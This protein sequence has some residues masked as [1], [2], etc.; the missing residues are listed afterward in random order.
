MNHYSNWLNSKI[1][2]VLLVIFVLLISFLLPVQGRGKER[3]PPDKPP[4]TPNHNPKIETRLERISTTASQAKPRAVRNTA[5]G[6]GIEL[7]RSNL[8]DVIV[9]EKTGSTISQTALRKVG[10]EVLGQTGNL[11]KV[12][13]P[14]DRIVDMAENLEGI[15]YVRSPYTSTTLGY[16]ST[17]SSSSYTSRGTNLI[18]GGLYH[19]NNYL[20]EGVK[21]AVIDL[22]FGSLDLAEEA[23]EIPGE[24]IED[25]EDYTGSGIY[26]GTAH[27]TGV[28]EIVHG[29]APEANLYL[30][31]IR[32]E[33]DLGEATADA[34][35]QGID[36]IV[37]SVGWLNTNFGDGT[38]VIAEIAEDA[39][40]A[41]ILWV[42]AAGN[43][44]RRHWEGQ[45]SDRDED[46]WVEFEGGKERI[47]VKNEIGR[48]IMVYLTWND[49]PTTG[50]D[51]DLYL[52]DED[53][54]LVGSSDNHQTGNEPPAEQIT[55][56]ASSGEYYLKVSGP[57]DSSDVD[58]EIY[59]LNQ[60]LEPRVDR[61]SVMAPGNAE[62]VFTVGAINE[63]NWVNGPIE[64]YSSR[65]PTYD[66][67]IKPDLTGIDGITLYTYRSFLGT[68]A[69]APSVGGAGA[70][71][72]SR[73]PELDLTE[74]K[75]ALN[76]NAK[77]LGATGPD[78]TYG[79]GRIRLIFNNPSV[80]RALETSDDS[81]SPGEILTVS[82]TAKM[83]LTLQGGLTVEESV[84]KPLEIQ[85]VVAP[86]TPVEVSDREVRF[87]WSIV[88]P[89]TSKE[90]VYKVL[91]PESIDSGEYEITGTING[92]STESTELTV[93]TEVSKVNEDAL[94]LEGARAVLD[95][96]SSSTEFIAS[97][98][99]V[100]EIRVKV[101]N[102]LGKEVFDSDWREGNTFQW[103]L[104]DD[105]GESVPNGVYLYFVTVKGPGGEIERSEL[106][107]TLVLR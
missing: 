69:A 11:K 50:L 86:G 82:S 55:H 20:G 40:E 7:T 42:N 83:P 45:A 30:K 8:V 34:I 38:G 93:S 63:S 92:N 26:S 102:L 94:I 39:A 14:V 36:V 44:A 101:Y 84:P 29:V 16:N 32:D 57:E 68:S 18:G 80:S 100:Y 12:R 15:R 89:G 107:K 76:Q 74:L 25:T 59:S 21:I 4:K 47:T 103:N 88:E 37:H 96:F 56:S 58:L 78:N 31:K 9:E 64:P 49:W 27:G 53:G 97:G 90:I 67:R 54:N 51:F 65:G 73:S 61:S 72:L 35:S 6:S 91:V 41:G 70:L 48:D 43:S 66:G 24:V 10:G 2:T 71:I 99:N 3:V 75:E 98:E 1:F 23:G 13:L 79:K 28:A 46:G 33:V 62:G 95:D 106:N 85:E 87:D 60:A 52:Y 81:I 5:P 104:L 17:G 19:A 77:D 22:G 105:G